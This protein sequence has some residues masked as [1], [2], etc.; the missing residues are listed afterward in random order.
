MVGHVRLARP[1]YAHGTLAMD[2][3]M[4]TLELVEITSA[5]TRRP[6]RIEVGRP[7]PDGRGAWACSVLAQ[8]LD[9]KVREIYGEDS[10]QALCLAI[11]HVHTYLKCVL[12]QG[13]RLVHVDGAGEFSL[14]AYFRRSRDES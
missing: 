5:D 2:F 11:R 9:A 4:A 7:H 10:F 8:G 3:P 14:E 1:H 13:S 12:E 6:I